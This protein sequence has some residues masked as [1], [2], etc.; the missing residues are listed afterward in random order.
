MYKWFNRV[1]FSDSQL[2]Y[3]ILR[4]FEQMD[5]TSVCV[6]YQD[7][8]WGSGIAEAVLKEA[9]TLNINVATAQK[10]TYTDDASIRNAVD[11]A[12]RYGTRIYVFAVLEEAWEKVHRPSAC[13][14]TPES[15]KR[16][17]DLVSHFWVC[18]TYADHICY[19]YKGCSGFIPMLVQCVGGVFC[20]TN[21]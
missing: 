15:G 18:V 17:N 2:V 11:V 19:G 10:F 3:G 16:Q 13:A 1:I 21:P 14:H 4:T 6:L 12:K 9:G 5:W 8:Q 20:S 7:D